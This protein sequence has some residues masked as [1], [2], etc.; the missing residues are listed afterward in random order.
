MTP[1]SPFECPSG[2]RPSLKSNL[3][4]ICGKSLDSTI[5]RDFNGNLV[6]GLEHGFYFSQYWE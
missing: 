2:R 5:E 3:V 4:A 6:G 1:G